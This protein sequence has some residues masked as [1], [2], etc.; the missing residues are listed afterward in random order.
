MDDQRYEAGVEIE[1]LQL[2]EATGGTPPLTYALM[3]HTPEPRT[4]RGA[5]VPGLSFD[6]DTRTLSGTPAEADTYQ[7]TY[8]ATDSE[9]ATGVLLFTISVYRPF[10]E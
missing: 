7:A 6:P 10:R 4:R 5:D 1:P 8:L 9:G 2:P 3:T